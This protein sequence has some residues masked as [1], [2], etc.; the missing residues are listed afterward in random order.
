MTART[1]ATTASTFSAAELAE[2]TVHRRAIEAI[3]WGIPIRPRQTP[4]RQDVGAAGYREDRLMHT[5]SRTTDP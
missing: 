3:T 5:G 2:R 1:S 4:V